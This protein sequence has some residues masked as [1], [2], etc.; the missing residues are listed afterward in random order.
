MP[1]PL[2]LTGLIAAPHTPLR[3]DGSLNPDAISAQAQ[4]LRESGVSGVFIAGSTGESLSLTA[5][6]RLTLAERWTA[7]VGGSL[8]VIVHVGHNSLPDAQALARQAAEVG[9]TAI[10]AMAPCYF[11]PTQLDDLIAFCAA[12]AGAAPALPFYY[13]DIPTM[14]NV[15]IATAQFLSRGRERI[16]TLHGVKFTNNDLPTLQECL[17]LDSFDV[18]FGYDEMLLA[19]LALGVRGAVGATYNFAAPLYQ[20]LLTAFDSGDWATARHA[21]RQSV[22]LIR[23]LQEFGFSR[24]SKAMMQLLGVDC[25]PVRSPLR[26]MTGPE[27]RELYRRL[28]DFDGL[29]RPLREPRQ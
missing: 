5:A 16:P 21:Q 13:Y 4:L 28:R 22:V 1:F 12:I 27:V 14:T 19:G 15:P 7:C 6:E 8:P 11:R 29:A 23:T 26:P 18:L 20:R 2:R 17:A 9:A 25:G 10:A 3:P 24:A